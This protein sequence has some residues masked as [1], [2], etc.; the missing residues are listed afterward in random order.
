MLWKYNSAIKGY[1]AK[2]IW[3]KINM[4]MFQL[5]IRNILLFLIFLFISF[6]QC[7][8]CSNFLLHLKLVLT[9][10]PTFVVLILCVCVFLRAPL[11]LVAS[12][13]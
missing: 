13:W 12:G 11:S 10:I 3:G 6:H 5:K 2:N 4:K 8:T 1:T 7:V 9:I